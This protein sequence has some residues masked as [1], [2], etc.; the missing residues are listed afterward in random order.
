MPYMFFGN[1]SKFA[2]LFTINAEKSLKYSI[3]LGIKNELRVEIVPF[4]VPYVY[5]EDSFRVSL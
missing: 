4:K 1:E 3:V 5:V 2:V